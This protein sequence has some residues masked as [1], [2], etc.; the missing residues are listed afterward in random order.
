MNE[1]RQRL[2]ECLEQ[3]GACTYHELAGK[4]AVS[5][6]TIR[7]DVDAL[8][9]QG[10]AIKTLGGA[11]RVSAPSFLCEQALQTRL[12]T[13][14]AEKR[15]IACQAVGLLKGQQTLFIDG[16][17]TC[18]EFA[19]VLAKASR[20]LMIVTNSALVAVAS[21]QNRENAVVCLGGDY[22]PDSMSFVGP[23]SEDAAVRYFVDMAFFSTKGFMAD[24]GTF[25][26]V[27]AN[28][29]IKQT[30]ARQAKKVILLADHTKFGQR[31]LCK[32]LDISQIQVV[33]TD[34]GAPRA[35]LALLAD[36]GCSVLVAGSGRAAPVAT[37]AA[38]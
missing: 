8:A 38:V 37:G 14:K 26:S 1:R 4:F 21:G 28:F 5:A 33:V 10:A 20:G 12:D 15:I 22:D 29:R 2:L 34:D 6:M 27:A 23:G 24:Q 32:V 30:I 7:R 18:W 19:R 13:N 35:D 25:E 16:S 3:Q 31:A 9:Q 36:R 17:T 11:Q